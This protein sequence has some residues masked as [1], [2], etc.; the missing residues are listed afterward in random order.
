MIN[1]KI[2]K[3]K[4]LYKDFHFRF[5][6]KNLYDYLH[7]L[8]VRTF[9]AVIT[10]WLTQQ[11]TESSYSKGPTWPPVNNVDAWKH[12]DKLSVMGSITDALLLWL[13]KL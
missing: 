8:H 6:S 4:Y 9:I 11:A 1:H 12:G 7:G 3:H 10:K 5:G 13:Q 2:S